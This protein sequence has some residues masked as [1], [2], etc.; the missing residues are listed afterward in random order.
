MPRRS[1]V[2]T[3]D[4]NP[5]ELSLDVWLP[6]V[7]AMKEG[8]EIRVVKEHEDVIVIGSVTVEREE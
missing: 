5:N 7:V 2:V 6:T 3:L 1:Y 8:D 4:E